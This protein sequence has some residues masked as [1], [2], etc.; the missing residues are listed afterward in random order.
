MTAWVVRH[1][2]PVYPALTILAGG[3][4]YWLQPLFGRMRTAEPQ[5]A[6]NRR[7]QRSARAGLKGRAD[8][9]GRAGLKTRPHYVFVVAIATVAMLA[10][11]IA[12]SVTIRPDYLAYFNQLAGGPSQGYRH[13][14]DS[15]LDWGQDLPALKQWLDRE[16]LQ[17][18]GGR[19]AYL[20]YFG[21]ARPEYYGITAIPLA[22]FIDRRPAQPPDPLAAGVYCISAT[23]LDVVG[24]S[25]YKPE[26][27]SNYQ[28][29]LKNL[30]AF[31]RA[32]ENEAAWS[33]LLRQTGEQYWHDLFKQF[34][35]LR[36]GRLVAFL[37]SREPDAMV[38]YS[39]LIYRLSDRDVALAVNGPPPGG[40]R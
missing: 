31:A 17:Q 39:I 10:W 15:S 13:L 3:A 32:S 2:L 37:R 24:P 18:P 26:D 19:K 40:P 33:A 14:A 29:A 16:G 23:V 6:A 9:K 28:A 1:L 34:D 7:Q 35:Q 21:T 20:S 30:I 11:H 36:T 8:L 38:G 4:A 5:N 27:E 12:E 22:G 25:F